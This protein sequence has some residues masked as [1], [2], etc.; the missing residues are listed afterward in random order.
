MFSRGTE[1]NQWKEM[2]E[3]LKFQNSL[4]HMD[5]RVKYIS[6]SLARDESSTMD[7]CKDILRITLK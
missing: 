4:F 2:D 7:G 6:I 1:T 3:R 5:L